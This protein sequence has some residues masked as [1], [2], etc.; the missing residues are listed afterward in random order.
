MALGRN[1]TGIMRTYHLIGRIGNHKIVTSVQAES[2]PKALETL[3]IHFPLSVHAFSAT[4]E[5]L[6][7][8]TGQGYQKLIWPKLRSELPGHAS[9]FIGLTS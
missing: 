5:L 9:Y 3:A 1:Q 4:G 7:Q 2:L 6:L 8:D